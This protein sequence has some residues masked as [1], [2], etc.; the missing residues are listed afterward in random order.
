MLLRGIM[1]YQ[2]IG[3]F[4]KLY[5]KYLT[6]QYLKCAPQDFDAQILI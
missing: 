5:C 6:I 1:K 3:V 4:S 2:K